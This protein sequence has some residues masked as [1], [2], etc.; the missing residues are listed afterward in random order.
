MTSSW[1]SWT[2]AAAAVAALLLCGA[3]ASGPRHE[4][5]LEDGQVL[6]TF[7][8]EEKA[9]G[10][11][12]RYYDPAERV[13]RI[14]HRDAADALRQ[15]SCVTTYEYD[16]FGRVCWERHLDASG[17][18]RRCVGGFASVQHSYSSDESGN[19]VIEQ[20]YR[21]ESN[22]SARCA[23]G[24]AYARYVY[25]G[26]SGPVAEIHL[27]DE[28]RQPTPV[29][30]DG[31]AGTARV[32][33][34]SLE[35]V[36]EVRCAVY[37]GPGGEILDRRVLSGTTSMTQHSESTTVRTGPNTTMTTTRTWVTQ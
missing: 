6:G 4:P 27:Q 16:T 15:D 33:I 8:R 21:D 37:F 34:T 13:V 12:L 19:L 9:G 32:T 1:S 28:A 22:M 26:S 2:R 11:E 24:Y 7:T 5:W 25:R 35:G 10:F 29:V 3:C 18:P 36:G 20:A 31:V 17:A 30:W 14:E 23:S